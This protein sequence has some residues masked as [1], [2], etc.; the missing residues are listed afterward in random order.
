MC[1]DT[2]CSSLTTCAVMFSTAVRFGRIPKREK[3]RMLL[4]MQSAMNNMMNNSQLHGSSPPVSSSQTQSCPAKPTAHAPPSFSPASSPQSSQSELSNDPEPS[5]P[6][7]TSPSS[8]SSSATDSG[9]EEVVGTGTRSGH[10]GER[11]T[12]NTQEVWNHH[13]NMATV[14]RQHQRLYYTPQDTPEAPQED[15]SLSHCPVRVSNSAS[16]GQCHVQLLANVDP[17]HPCSASVIGQPLRAHNSNATRANAS[18][19]GP[20]WSGGNRMHLVS[21]SESYRK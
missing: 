20:A 6:M 1:N 2:V 19:T 9:E 15:N 5:L 10:E 4:E 17:S 16:G 7:D 14:T 18:Y 12:D 21:V 3:Q 8:D 13:N 11:V